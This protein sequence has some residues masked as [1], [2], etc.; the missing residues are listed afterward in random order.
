MNVLVLCAHADD[1]VIAVGG[2]IRKL[3]NAGALIRLVMFS[4]G[5]EG[6]SRT[7]MKGQIVEQRAKE[8]LRVC[9]ILGIQE[10]F[11]LH[12][13]DWDLR[14]GNSTYKAVIHH[15]RQFRPDMIFVH[16][17]AD[18]NDHRV[19]HDVGVEGWFH[20][21]I[22]CAMEE[23]D[24]W[25]HAPLFLYEVL[26][27]MSRPTHIVDITDTYAAKIEAM[28][29]YA[30]QHELV[31]GVFQLMEGRSLERGYLIGAKYGEALSL[32]AYRP[33]PV[34]NVASLADL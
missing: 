1:E 9:E 8:T 7:E 27:P 10:Y 24:V 17:K 28:R 4:E 5:A 16:H 12:H 20:A 33:R 25:R 3:A 21:G 32:A 14:V 6:Y 34:S 29:E 30:T 15:V 19:V 26:Q 11:N 13:L 18:Y 22:P 31:G 2:I 23:G